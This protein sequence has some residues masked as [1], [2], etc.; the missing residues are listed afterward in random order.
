MSQNVYTF[1]IFMAQAYNFGKFDFE[2]WVEGEGQDTSWNFKGG[3]GS[4]RTI[5]QMWGL[6]AK[7]APK[8]NIYT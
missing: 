4:M 6:G 2:M 1:W 3:F 8:P 5:L 7:M